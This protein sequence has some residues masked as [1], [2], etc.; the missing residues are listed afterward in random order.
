MKDFRENDLKGKQPEPADKDV[1]DLKND[2][3]N[4]LLT[5]RH[6]VSKHCS[7]VVKKI[8]KLVLQFNQ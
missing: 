3:I 1:E 2:V 7:E 4:T 8:T 6:K 5:Y